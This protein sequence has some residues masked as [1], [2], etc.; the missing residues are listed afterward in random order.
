MYLTLALIDIVT[1]IVSII[2]VRKTGILTMLHPA[3]LYW[4]VHVYCFTARL[5]VLASGAPT[6]PGFRGG[7][8]QD[9]IVRAALLADLSLVGLTVGWLCFSRWKGRVFNAV[10]VRVPSVPARSAAWF[11]FVS[12]CLLVWAHATRGYVLHPLY[13]PDLAHS[14]SSYLD[15]FLCLGMLGLCLLHHVI[16]FP[17]LLTCLTGLVILFTGIDAARFNLVVGSLLLYGTYASRK[18][19]AWPSKRALLVFGAV[20]ILFLPLKTVTQALREGSDFGTVVTETTYRMVH[21]VDLDKQDGDTQFLDMAASAI[22]LTDNAG[23]RAFGL[24]WLQI[25]TLPIPR[26]WWPEKPRVNEFMWSIETQDRPMGTMGMVPM[27]VGDGFMN[28]GTIGCFIVPFMVGI[29]SIRFYGFAMARPHG[30]MERFLYLLFLAIS[31]Q[32]Y[33][34]GVFSALLFMIVVPYPLIVF[35]VVP[36]LLLRRRHRKHVR[37]A[38]PRLAQREAAPTVGD[39]R[40]PCVKPRSFNAAFVG[41]G[42]R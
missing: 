38:H 33:R 29:A 3:P 14:T 12:C 8:T 27:L 9:E 32:V 6:M 18:Q 1:L 30:S 2:F 28:F 37:A 20:G 11:A 40:G 4:C 25:F 10:T 35:Y 41:G 19:I 24:P 31:I 17:R 39:G 34:D 21:I 36:H 13:S 42:Q 23:K 7:I 16:G 5:F 15:C 26:Q 22:T